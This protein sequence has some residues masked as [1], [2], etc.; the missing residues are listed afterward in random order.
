MGCIYK[1]TNIINNKSY[2]GLTTK[3]AEYRFKQHLNS[4]NSKV[5]KNCLLHKALRKYGNI[6]FKIETLIDNEFN[7]KKLIE[8]EQFYI[9]KYNTY[10]GISKTGYNLTLGGEGGLG[11]IISEETKLKMKISSKL[12]NYKPSKES[13]EQGKLNRMWYKPSIET[14][15]KISLGNKGKIISKEC[16]DKISKKLK[17]HTYTKGISKSE[18]HKKKVSL[19]VKKLFASGYRHSSSK[20]CYIYDEQDNLLHK[21]ISASEASR[22]LNI[23]RDKL[24]NYKNLVYKNLKIKTIISKYEF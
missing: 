12:R 11:K 16:R 7:I 1:I 17:G 8:L 2:I 21:F 23:S 24:T 13:I 5:N 19:S 6:N 3:T 15:L 22:V 20:W 14:K 10:S 9:K 18:E 4:K